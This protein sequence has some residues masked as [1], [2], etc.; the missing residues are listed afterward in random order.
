M[1]HFSGTLT[2]AATGTLNQL[3]GWWNGVAAGDFDGDGQMDLVAGNWGRNTRFEPYAQQPVRLY[4]GDF[5]GSGGVDLL[6]AY[7]DPE[8]RAVAPWRS[9][10]SVASSMPFVQ[11]QFATHRAYAQASVSQVLGERM[12]QARELQA[13][14]LQTTLFLNRGGQFVAQALPLEAQFA[15]AFGVCVG[16][17]DGDGAEDIF[18]S[19]NFFEVHPEDSPFVSGRGL[20]LKGDGRGGCAAVP[21]QVSGVKI[22]GEQRGAALADFDGDG[23]VDLGV[24]QNGGPTVLLRNVGGKPG[25]RVR[26]AGPKGNPTG[27]GAVMRLEYAEHQ[28]PGRE[29]HAGAGYWSQDSAVQV[30]GLSGTPRDVWVRWPG[31]RVTRAPV[32]GGAREV[33]VKWGQ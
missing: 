13:Q 17:F 1:P 24:A 21:G 12:K 23:R 31:G 32:P 30:L 19:Q 33:V 11:E 18:L 14:W 2:S 7:Y 5:S 20:W 3:T 4:Y 29:L 27:I 10:G 15:P 28:G 16:D 6:E 25:L 26:L 8:M 22:Y 9:F